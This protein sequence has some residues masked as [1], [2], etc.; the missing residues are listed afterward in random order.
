MTNAREEVD[1]PSDGLEILR[2]ELDAA[3]IRLREALGERIEIC[4]RIAQHK[5]QYGIPMMQPHRIGVVQERAARF[6]AEHKI[7]Q[8]FI[9]QFDDLVITETCRIEDLVIS[10]EEPD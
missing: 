8:T 1:H 3:D 4:V 9:R 10:E 7:D 2:A 5:R 6:A